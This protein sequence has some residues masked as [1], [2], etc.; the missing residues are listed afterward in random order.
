MKKMAKVSD[1]AEVNPRIPRAVRQGED[2]AVTF[3][4]MASVSE[5]GTVTNEQERRLSDVLTGYTYFERGDVLIAKIT[6]CFENGKA[7]LTQD[8]R[9]DLGFGTT[10]FHVL[11]PGPDVDASY[12]F[13]C[14][15]TP[16]FR[17]FG[18]AKMVGTG[19]QLRLPAYAFNQFD[20]PLPPLSE[21]RRVAA[22]LDRA[23]A[24][25]R[26]RREA[27]SLADALLRSAFADLFGDAGQNRWPV[28]PLG[29]VSDVGSGVMKGRKFNGQPTV[30]L[31]YLRV[32]NVQDGHLDLSEIKTIRALASDVERYRLEDGDVLITEGGDHDK[33][34]R[35]AIWRNEIEG[36]IHQNHVFRVR[37]DRT[38]MRPEYLAG[39][40]MTR[41]SKDYFL[42]AAK[43]TTNL[44]TINMTQLRGLPV[45]LPPTDLQRRY[46]DLV[47]TVSRCRERMTAAADAGEALAASITSSAFAEV[48][49][50]V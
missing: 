5:S 9:H 7:C 24:L 35:G 41:A 1:V 28:V 40:L 47:C 46:D 6:P 29:D 3:L 4:P 34:G 31:S 15:H 16:A 8:I 25:R 33:L 36:C 22:V 39:F 43:R 19:G 14:L 21:Q 20:I 23:D 2:R 42:R 37:L 18:E 13:R 32:A 45:P 50:G 27:L 44:A 10:E 30:E 11:R 48:P 49:H 12:L 38:R 17:R 26:R